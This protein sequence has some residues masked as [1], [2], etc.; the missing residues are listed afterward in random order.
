MRYLLRSVL[1][2]FLITLLA[3]GLHAQGVKPM[4]STTTTLT[5]S[6]NPSTYGSTVTLTA[7]VSGSP[8]GGTVTFYNTGVQIGMGNCNRGV[9]T[10]TTSS[11]IVGTLP[12]TAYYGGTSG[13]NPSMSQTDYQTVNKANT[14]VTQP[15]STANPST[16]GSSVTF[17]STVT[18]SS[19]TGSITF[20]DGSNSLGSGTISGGRAS[21]ST[22]TLSVGSHSITATYNGDPNDNAS[23]PSS[24]LSQT[25][26]K[27][28]T[29]VTQPT[30]TANPS[31]YGSSVTFASTVTPSSATGTITFKDGSNSL[32]NGTI[33][34]GSASLSTSTLSAGSHSITATYNGDTNFNA[35]SPSSALSQTVNKA[36]SYVTQP[37]SSQ[38]PST[39]GNAVTFTSTVTPSSATG[40]ITFY[41]GS[42][43][44]GNGGVSNGSA[45]LT[46][47]ALTVGSHSITATYNGDSNNNASSPSSALVQTVNG[48][49]TTQL[50]PYCSP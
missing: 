50:P 46:T 19:A 48:P 33:S 18:P 8:S 20:K 23:S 1:F 28:N 39:S 32:G 12:L 16:Y 30:S 7:T 45:S 10:M 35:S 2:L 4:V 47:S 42:N 24:A 36:S 27:A 37:T 40:S 9:A 34:G 26:N 31:T 6:P 43:S 25:V 38:N 11:L 21:L 44:I 17:T 22:S 3:A 5:S 14:S 13:Y 29:S 49:P 41:D 15:T